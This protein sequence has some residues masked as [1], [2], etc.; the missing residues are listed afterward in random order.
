MLSSEQKELSSTSLSVPYWL[1]LLKFNRVCPHR[2]EQYREIEVALIAIK[3]SEEL[4]LLPYM[5]AR[6]RECASCV[7]TLAAVA[8]EGKE[9]LLVA[10]LC[11]TVHAKFGKIGHR[12]CYR[13]Y[14]VH[15]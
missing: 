3:N 5:V 10:A 7:L 1:W 4:M 6:Q 12:F 8:R 9:I 14:D 2:I 11:S 15:T 13:M